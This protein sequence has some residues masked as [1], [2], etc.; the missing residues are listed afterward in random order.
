MQVIGHSDF[1]AALSLVLGA[2]ALPL[3]LLIVKGK[4]GRAKNQR[5][6]NDPEPTRIACAAIASDLVPL[7]R[8]L[9]TH[10]PFKGSNLWI[11]GSDG[12]YI[13]ESNSRSS[14]KKLLSRMFRKWNVEERWRRE[15]KSWTEAGL[16]ITYILLEANDDVR[17]SLRDLK[18]ELGEG[19]DAFILKEGAI[20]DDVQALRTYHPTLFMGSQGENAAWI[21]G[22]HPP[23]SIYAYDVTYVS[24]KAMQRASEKE[25]FDA[26]KT[27]LSLVKANSDRLT[28]T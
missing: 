6:S 22:W 23:G 21:E 19:F 27:R 11:F 9:R 5:P 1:W 3:A 24:P 14:I 20:E 16:K 2:L 18:K 15:F 13:V 28:L 26:C 10:V 4:D 17:E 12:Q 8:R 25:V 7:L